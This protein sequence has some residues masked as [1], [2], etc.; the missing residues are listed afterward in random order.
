[1]N[2]FF[3][4]IP[5]IRYEGPASA[6]P[7]SFKY[8]N[9]DQVIMGKTMREHL[10]FAMAWWHNMC[11]GGTDMFGRDTADKSFGCEKGTMEYAK[12]KVDAGFEFM[13]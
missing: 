13:Q 3:P 5:V 1:M 10:P 7:L 8:Y 12:A 6:N 2:K 11:A 4:E 9:P